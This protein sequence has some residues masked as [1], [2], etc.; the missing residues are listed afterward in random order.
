[1]LRRVRLRVAHCARALERP[2]LEAATVVAPFLE[3]GDGPGGG[4]SPGGGRR[5]RPWR[6]EPRSLM[7]HAAAVAEQG[8]VEWWMEA[9][10]M[11]IGDLGLV[12]TLYLDGRMAQQLPSYP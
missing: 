12:P 11:G 5:R 2:F 1:M 8:S 7:R 6:Q 9:A 4:D 3:A 10:E